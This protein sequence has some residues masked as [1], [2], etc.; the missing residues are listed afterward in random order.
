[1]PIPLVI[2]LA[3]GAFLAL[4]ARRNA[5]PAQARA[6]VPRHQ[7][8]WAEF[9]ALTAQASAALGVPE[10]VLWVVATIESDRDP[11]LANTADPR[12]EGRGGAWGLFQMT[13]GTAKDLFHRYPDLKRAP[14]AA[15][16]D[17]TG[18]SLLNPRLNM[19]LA[20]AYLGHAWKRF[21]SMWPTIASYHQGPGPVRAVL[22][23][24]GNLFS[25]LP[26]KGRIYLARAR[27]A[28]ADIEAKQSGRG[29]LTS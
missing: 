11:S 6:R 15:A 22:A 27:R 18:R 10:I 17:G 3:A 13:L 19:L 24:G 20:A 26:P 8:P 9:A 7:M 25:D 23:R 1:M 16:W 4:T 12:A 29:A 21:G 5:E 2:P 14:A 28:F